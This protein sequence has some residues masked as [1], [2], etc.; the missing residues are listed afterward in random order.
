MPSIR[1][2]VAEETR[3]HDDQSTYTGV[4][5]AGGPTIVDRDKPTLDHLLNRGGAD[6]RGVTPAMR[7]VRRGATTS[8]HSISTRQ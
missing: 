8:H 4:H 3:F 7:E 6:I 5:K 2:T 1:G